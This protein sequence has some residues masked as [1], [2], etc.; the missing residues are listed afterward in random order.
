MAC[1]C[2]GRPARRS[3]IPRDPLHTNIR[4]QP[5]SCVADPAIRSPSQNPPDR[6]APDRCRQ[7]AGPSAGSCQGGQWYPSKAR[8][9]GVSP[10]RVTGPANDAPASR[11]CLVTIQI[12]A[13]LVTIDR[14]SDRKF[15][16]RPTRAYREK[17]SPNYL[18]TS[19]LPKFLVVA[20]SSIPAVLP[21]QKQHLSCLDSNLSLAPFLPSWDWR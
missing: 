15:S 14:I 7:V 19:K 13:C 3:P 20:S 21:P 17:K 18:L 1:S 10:D 4:W 16:S 2:P 9:C 8:G 5:T 11:S 12:F 6:T